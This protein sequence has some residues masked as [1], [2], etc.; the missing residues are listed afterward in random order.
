[1]PL[2][3][4]SVHAEVEVE[5]EVERLLSASPKTFGRWGLGTGVTATRFN[6]PTFTSLY[7]KAVC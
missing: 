1:M 4:S 2:L 5:V 3:C 7:L 6:N